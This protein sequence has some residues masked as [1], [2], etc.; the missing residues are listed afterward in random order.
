MVRDPESSPLSNQSSPKNSST[1]AL[2]AQSD[3]MQ[4]I[5]ERIDRVAHSSSSLLLIGETVI[6]SAAIT[7]PLPKLYLIAISIK[8]LR[9]MVT[10]LSPD[11]GEALPKVVE[12]ARQILNSD[13]DRV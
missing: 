9:S 8:E 11:I 6:E 7:G 3:V 4:G 10:D 13:K 5:L 2:I 1:L 12:I